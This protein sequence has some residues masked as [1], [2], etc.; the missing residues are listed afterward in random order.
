MQI[1]AAQL[2]VVARRTLA[3]DVVELTLRRP[4][5]GRLPDWA[6]GAHV[7]VT[8]P[9]GMVRPY[10][11]C[12]DRWDP[13]SYTL[14]VRREV[15]GSGGSAY[16]HDR[17]DVGSTVGVGAPRT[18]F[19][20]VPASA[21]VFVA[22][23]IGV[24]P[25]LPM[26]QAADRLGVPY[27]L[28]YLGRDA[29]R[30]PYLADLTGRLG[31]GRLQVHVTGTAGRPD[32]AAAVGPVPDGGRVYGCGPPGLHRALADLARGWPEHTLWT[33]AFGR[34]VGQDTDE[35]FTVR[36][37]R[38]GVTVEVPRTASLLEAI[39]AAGV[40]VL[41]SCRVGSCGA[42]ETPVL[43]GAVEHR[44]TILTDDDAGVMFPC[45]SRARTGLL[46]LDL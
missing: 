7:A 19:P 15:A 10:S 35:A 41:S 34:P 13:A 43:R 32:L 21:Y 2:D 18:S 36:L 30:M 24:T 26:M 14:A 38:T 20:L 23:G 42:C 27:R 1:G 8:L 40:D 31:D 6:P 39:H 11:L 3:R 17:L 4:D 12:G 5:G 33:E 29:D 46:E 25:F 45:V 9:N 22:G 16:V 37:R 44:D 28:V